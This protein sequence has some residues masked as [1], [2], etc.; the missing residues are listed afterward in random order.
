MSSPATLNLANY[1]TVW[2]DNFGSDHSLNS[3]LWPVKWGNS[4]DF[5]FSN[6]CMTLT[7]Y[8]SEGWS[9][10]GFMQA[11][12]GATSAQGYG[13]YSMTASTDPN[14]G[15]GICIVM[16]PSDN[17]WPGAEIDLLENW[18]DP[19]QHT[20]YCTI[21]WKGAGNSNGQDPHQFN[22]DLT[23]K[24]TYAMDWQ[25]GS[26][27]YYIDGQYMFQITGSEV[28]LDAADGGVNESF[29]AEVT[30]AGSNAVS[31]SV[32]LHIYD[33]SFSAYTGVQS[34][35]ITLSAP[36]SVQ[37]ASV[38]AGVNVTETVSA[39]GLHTIYEAVYT[40][41]NV[42]ESSWTAVTLNS[43]GS[44]TFTAQ[45]QHSGDYVVVV[46]DPN[47]QTAKGV[48]APITITDQISTW[49]DISSPGT[50]REASLGAGVDVT[51][52][53]SAPGLHTI[54]EVVF[55]SANV[56][57]S[58]WTAV[59]LNSAGSG[60][61]TAHFQHSGDYL[62]AVDDPNVQTA[63]GWSTPI[64]ITDTLLAP[65]NVKLT[66][67]NLYSN[68]KAA[69]VI[70]TLSATDSNP[71][72]FTLA[73][74]PGSYFAIAG[75]KLSLAK[76]APVAAPKSVSISVVATDTVTHL[77]T[78]Q[79]IN[80]GVNAPLTATAA[81]QITSASVRFSP[82]DGSDRMIFVPSVQ[83]GVVQAVVVGG[84]SGDVISFG[85]GPSD[86]WGGTGA[87]NFVFH[88]GDGFQTIETFSAAKGDVL[89]I[90]H[91]LQGSLLESTAAGGTMLSF[92]D[93][94]H[95]ILL[96]GVVNFSASQIHWN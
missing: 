27:T 43:A 51:Q 18:S 26:L 6:G 61:F 5:S 88:A 44:G 29:G 64:T 82:G 72:S 41:G 11:D 9:N 21:H 94:A 69:T 67:D 75:N 12:Y 47:T 76:N 45:F 35:S 49:I 24:H 92:G 68:S 55:T 3:S 25:R 96:A 63:K 28:P 2:S 71:V 87:D 89:T 91:A 37:E 86:V 65:S 15:T 23:Q 40:S 54:Y 32:S 22:I 4:N 33:A 7:S 77:A 17:S 19:S 90:D 78:T 31:S 1:K 79:I 62:L 83:P 70:G 66:G 57:E 84:G 81:G 59:T 38:G 46:N 53:V 10:V 58:N 50:V 73:S 16:W 60:T 36:G 14:Q 42:A 8:A 80:V 30:A 93:N 34:S 20:G 74:N 52:T 95:A 85:I 56:A 39:P 13:L 48:S